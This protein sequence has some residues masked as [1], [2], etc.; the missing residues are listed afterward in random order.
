MNF[1]ITGRIG[2]REEHIM[3]K[4]NTSSDQ[5]DKNKNK[6]VFSLLRPIFR[7]YV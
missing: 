3:D 2:L 7:K 1:K 6:S 4:N 5:H